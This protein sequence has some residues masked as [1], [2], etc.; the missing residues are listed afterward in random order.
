MPLSPGLTSS[1]FS[2]HS[3]TIWNHSYQELPPSNSCHFLRKK[4]T[5]CFTLWPYRGLYEEWS[6]ARNVCDIWNIAIATL[7]E[8]AIPAFMPVFRS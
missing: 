3:L 5:W 2:C 6:G 4:T 1:I 8:M 7:S